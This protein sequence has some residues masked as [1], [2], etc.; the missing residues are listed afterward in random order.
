MAKVLVF[1][2]TKKSWRDLE[3]SN[4]AFDKV[5]GHNHDGVNSRQGTGIPSNPPSGKCKVVN[6]YVDPGTGKTV[7]EYDNTPV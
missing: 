3:E 6:I 5:A 4:V 1:D 2:G 7:V